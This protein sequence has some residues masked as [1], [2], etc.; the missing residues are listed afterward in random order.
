MSTNSSTPALAPTALPAPFPVIG[1]KDVPEASGVPPLLG[2]VDVAKSEGPGPGF[3]VGYIFFAL[4]LILVTRQLFYSKLGGRTEGER[5]NDND[6]TNND[7]E[8]AQRLVEERSAEQRAILLSYFEA[9]HT[10]LV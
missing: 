5:N 4:F 6:N 8:N 9:A 1:G 10:E 7:R 2:V 3:F